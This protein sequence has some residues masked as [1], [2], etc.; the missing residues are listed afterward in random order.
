MEGNGGRGQWRLVLSAAHD[1][2]GLERRG[3]ESRGESQGETEFYD[4]NGEEESGGP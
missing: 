2:T 3:E 1:R 4:G